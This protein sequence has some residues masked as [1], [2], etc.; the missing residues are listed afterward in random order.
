MDV[1]AIRRDFPILAREVSGR[2]LVYLDNPAT[3]QKPRAVIEALTRF[4]ESSNANVHRGLHRLSEEATAQY[5]AA[6][7]AVASF[8]NAASP[9]EVV[10]TANTTAGIN[11]VA[12]GWARPRLKEGD[13]II[14]TEMEHHSNLVPWQVAAQRT[15]A[16]LRFVR[17]TDDFRLDLEDFGAA[18]RENAKIVALTHASNVLGT[19]NPVAEICRLAREAGAVSVVDGAQAAPHLPVDVQTIGCDFYALSGHKACG[20]TGSGALWGKAERLEET[21]PL[22]FGGSMI[23]RVRWDSSEW[24]P[25]PHKFEAGTPNIGEAIAFGEAMRYLTTLGMENLESYERELTEYGLRAVVEVP[26]ITLHGPHD[27]ADRLGVFSFSLEGVHPHDISQIVDEYGVAIRAGHHCCEPLHR[28]LGIP[29][30]ARAGI[31]LYNTREDLDTL[32]EALG[33][34]RQV[35]AVAR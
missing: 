23:S 13:T 31:Y 26:G 3:S 35:F 27:A 10:F 1:A 32:V 21:E 33:R 22:H 16:R 20:P 8:L 29:G 14:L 9:E 28:K 4:Y 25:P 7:A 2:P 30:S 12:Q 15:G 34:V 17:L 24:S 19:V 6:R 18:L 5:E 11:L